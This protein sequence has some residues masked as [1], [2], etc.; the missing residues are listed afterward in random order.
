MADF[1]IWGRIEPI[2]KRRYFVIV[3]ELPRDFP[4]N[5]SSTAV[6]TGT[7]DSR[8]EAT[9]L[10]D[11]LMKRAGEKIRARGDRMVDVEEDGP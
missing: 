10:R 8:E 11:G 9:A 2:G 4:S 7:V 5:A 6:E 3:S 1:I